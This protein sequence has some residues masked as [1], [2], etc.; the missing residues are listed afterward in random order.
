MYNKG[1][2]ADWVPKPL[3]LLLI[4]IFLFPM[5]AIMGVYTGNT[6]DIAGALATYTEYISL[7]NNATTIGMGVSITIALRI[8][9]RFR[10]KEIITTSA[11]ILA[12]LSFIIGTTDNPMVVVGGSFFIGFF[13]MFPIIEMILPVM[14][15]LSPSGDKGQFYAI[16]YPLSICIGHLSAYLMSNLIFNSTWQAPYFIMS[17]LMLIIAALSLIFQ[18]NKRFCFK[19]PLYQIDW[20]SL[21]LLSVSAMCINISLT[22]MQQQ[23]WFSSS[24]ITNFLFI[25]VLLLIVVIYRQKF[26]TRKLIKFN[27]IL[28]KINIWHSLLLLMLLGVYL[29]SSSI[30]VQYTVGVLGYNNLINAKLN[31]WMIP[32]IIIGGVYAFYSF[33]NKWQLKYYIATGF[34]AFFF[35]T[36]M[37]Y[38]MMQ[39]QMNIEVLY[40]AMIIKG[41]GMGILFIGIW[42]YASLDLE[43]DDLLG[44]MG[45]LLLVRTFVATAIG[46][47]IISWATYQGQWQSLNNISMYLDMGV[48]NDGLNMYSS[49]QLNAMMASSKKVLGS[50][51]WLTLP[52]LIFVITH[53]YGQF[54][55]RRVIFFKKVIR[56]NSIKGYRFS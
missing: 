46:G 14:F 12:L 34:I 42:F 32:G 50:L 30:F 25:G 10:S 22:F 40:I 48:F 11:I 43:M 19:M 29:A 56:G 8:K 53:H 33:K 6:T 13:K 16:F 9:M 35:H 20:L 36:L 15:I 38:L 18:H 47:A 52:I 37:L 5:M 27:L 49:S 2:F 31:L 7:A 4:I 28:K 23:G 3:M 51:C 17:I 44:I 54:N 39:P 26:M 24:Y 45:V 55:Y 21:V 41:M 1:P